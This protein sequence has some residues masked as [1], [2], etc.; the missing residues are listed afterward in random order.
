MLF[1]FLEQLF[2]RSNKSSRSTAKDRLKFV[3]AYD[4]AQLS[5]AA[6]ESMCEEIMGVLSKYVELDREGFEFNLASQSGTTALIANFPIRR[7]K[8]SRAAISDPSR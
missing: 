3:L 6:L 5:P 7:V 1:E 4:R 2:A 8:S